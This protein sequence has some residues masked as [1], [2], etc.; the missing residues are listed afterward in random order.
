M[1]F[2]YIKPDTEI[3]LTTA[4]DN[5]LNGGSVYTYGHTT[6]DATIPEGTNPTKD[7]DGYIWVDSK[8]NDN[9]WNDRW[10]NE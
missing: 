7:G 1:K 9:F 5:I 2:N 10:G 6:P 4:I 8:K 3:I